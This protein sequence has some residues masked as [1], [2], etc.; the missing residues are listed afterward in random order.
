MRRRGLTFIEVVVALAMLATF[1]T[2]VVGSIG[3]LVQLE[4]REKHRLQAIELAHRVIIQ[5]L[6]DSSQTP[7]PDQFVW[8]GD[9]KYRVDTEETIL[10]QET[11]DIEGLSQ[12]TAFGVGD[13]EITQRVQS[14]H[15]LTVRVY[16]YEPTALFPPDVPVIELARHYYPFL[17]DEEWA[18][19]WLLRLISER[20]GAPP[21]EN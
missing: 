2:L 4:E 9:T 20:T 11:S 6:D 14:M 5:Y 16:L 21:S 17:Q 8:Q 3:Y 13:V 15:K 7:D 18:Q 10:V 19:E 1:A 12:G